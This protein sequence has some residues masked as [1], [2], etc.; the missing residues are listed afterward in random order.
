MKT[1]DGIKQNII[2][3][4]DEIIGRNKLE[5][6][7]PWMTKDILDLIIKRNKLRNKDFTEYKKVKHEVTEKCKAAKEKWLEENIKEIEADM[8]LNNT[9][10]AYNKVK[11][12]QYKPKTKSNIVRDKEGKIL[13]ENSKVV[14]RWKEYMEE[15]YQGREIVNEEDYIENEDSVDVDFKGPEILKSEF[16]KSLKDLCDKKATGVD[17]IPAEILKNLDSNTEKLLFDVIKECYNKGTLPDDFVKSKT[18]TLPK[19][20]NASD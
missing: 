9:S 11:K 20:G 19:K 1:W 4:T 15:L 14:E 2:K 18:I 16:T 12:M 17:N 6:K 13:F 5:P 7:K 3:V 8:L 10:K